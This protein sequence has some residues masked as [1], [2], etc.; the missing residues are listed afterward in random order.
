MNTEEKNHFDTRTTYVKLENGWKYIHQ[1][2][3]RKWSVLKDP[4]I[5]KC[6]IQINGV[7][8]RPSKET[9][10]EWI[11]TF[12]LLRKKW[13]DLLG[14]TSNE[15]DLLSLEDACMSAQ[16]QG[17]NHYQ[18]S[19]LESIRGCLFT[20]QLTIVFMPQLKKGAKEIPKRIEIVE[21]YLIS[22]IHKTSSSN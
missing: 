14:C 16:L 1:A 4:S 7:D 12:P 20:P 21:Q 19:P 22:D 6:T 11:F 10:K 8:V 13:F 17:M 2:M 3:V 15:C 9:D 5:S 18:S